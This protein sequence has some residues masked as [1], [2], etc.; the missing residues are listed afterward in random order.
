MTHDHHHDHGSSRSHSH[1]HAHEEGQRMSLKEKL[2]VLLSHW[3]DHNDS[4][5]DN[6]YSWAQKAKEAGLEKTALHL[7]QA[8]DLSE[9]VTRQLEQAIEN[10]ARENRNG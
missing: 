1:D 7:E 10:L 9:Q 4:H 6:F 5:K 3:V 2:E 8:G